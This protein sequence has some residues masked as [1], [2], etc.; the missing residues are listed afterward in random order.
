MCIFG[1]Y[2][3][4]NGDNTFTA[5]RQY[6]QDLVVVTAVDVEIGAAQSSDFC[7]LRQVAASFF[8]SY[9]IFNFR[10]FCNCFGSQIATCS[11]GYVVQNDG[12]VDRMC[13]CGVVQ[14][15]TFLCCFV[16]VRCYQQN[17]VSTSFFTSLSQFDAVC[18]VDQSRCVRCFNCL[19]A[20]RKEA[21]SWK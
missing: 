21:M 20:C 2:V 4:Q 9:D 12:N 7:Y 17:A 18:W 19:G 14:N 8:Y 10:Q 16:V 11:A 3:G 6:G 15:L 5:Q 1:C 13:E